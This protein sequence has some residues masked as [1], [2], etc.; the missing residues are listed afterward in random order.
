MLDCHLST[1]HTSCPCTCQST[2]PPSCTA[3]AILLK[4]TESA[5]RTE[6]IVLSHRRF[7]SPLSSHQALSCGILPVEQVHSII[8]LLLRH[9]DAFR[10]I[11]HTHTNLYTHIVNREPS[12]LTD[13]VQRLLFPPATL[14]Y[15]LQISHRS[16]T[17]YLDICHCEVTNSMC[18][19]C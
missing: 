17:H 4:S 14:L 6:L 18:H 15:E 12:V 5:E 10:E 2:W 13:C 8:H 9:L 3:A 7:P 16:G 1:S 11:N 19:R